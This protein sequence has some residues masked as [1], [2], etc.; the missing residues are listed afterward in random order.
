MINVSPQGPGWLIFFQEE[1][2]EP[3]IPQPKIP[4]TGGGR[5]DPGYVRQR[6]DALRETRH[7]RILREDEEMVALI[8]AMVT[9]G[10]I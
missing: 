1:V 10:L 4:G 6:E 2:V 8:M 9:K 5:Y 3:P 7:K